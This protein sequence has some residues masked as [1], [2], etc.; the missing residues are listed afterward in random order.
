MDNKVDVLLLQETKMKKKTF[1][2][3]IASIWPRASFCVCEAEGASGGI[4]TLWN[5]SKLKGS[6]HFDSKN[7]LEITLE[8]PGSHESWNLVNIYA[9]NSSRDRVLLWEQLSEA[10]SERCDEH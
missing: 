7:H 6:F 8:D 4:A 2:K 1:E 10:I 5:P 9:P 3:A